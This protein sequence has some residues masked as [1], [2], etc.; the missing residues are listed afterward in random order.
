M[1]KRSDY[2]VLFSPVSNLTPLEGFIPDRV[3]WLT[4][5]ILR[6]GIWTT[7]IVIDNRHGLIMDGHHRHQVALGLN[8]KRIPVIAWSYDEVVVFSLRDSEDVSVHQILKNFESGI[9]YP[10]KTAKHEFP[11]SIESN[12]KVSL[13]ELR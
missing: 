9:L 10:N 1:A 2:Q 4:E 6:A 8:L 12:L 13:D 11:F 7:P 3:A 5:E